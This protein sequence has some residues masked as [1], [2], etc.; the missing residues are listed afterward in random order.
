M[1]SPINTIDIE[2]L[3]ASQYVSGEYSIV[4]ARVPL[5]EEREAFLEIT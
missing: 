2:H 5:G 1:A 4:D 3:E